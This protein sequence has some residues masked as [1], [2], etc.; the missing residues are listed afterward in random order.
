[1]EICDIYRAAF[2]HQ[3]FNQLLKIFQDHCDP[4]M[5]FI[6]PHS[7]RVNGIYPFLGYLMLANE[8]FPDV[9]VKNIEK[10]VASFKLPSP[11]K[12]NSVTTSL[13][14]SSF[15]QEQ[16][17]DSSSVSNTNNNKS[18]VT[19]EVIEMIDRYTGTRVLDK[20]L[21]A[22]YHQILQEGL[23]R[24]DRPYTISEL[25]QII[26]TKIA[27]ENTTPTSSTTSVGLGQEV[28]FLTEN[29]VTFDMQTNKIV[30][31]SYNILAVHT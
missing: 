22:F 20:P 19:T 26:S 14:I 27:E 21:I 17:T 5:L 23:I 18:I 28:T 2:N 12:P 30:M 29:S 25:S 6:A 31:W 8:I 15:Q 16:E 24:S 9:I 11:A 4:N 10:R 7:V 3:D 13:S 1:M